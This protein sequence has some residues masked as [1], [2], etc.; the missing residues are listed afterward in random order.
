MATESALLA[1]RWFA[2]YA[3]DHRHP[4]NQQLHVICVP[5]I[6]WSILAILQC[7][8]APEVMVT[9]LAA[10][11]LEQGAWAALAAAAAVLFWLWLSLPLGIGTAVLSALCFWVNASILQSFGNFVLLIAGIAVFVLAWIGQFVGHVV[12][13]RRPSFFTDLVYLLIGPPW[14]LAKAYRLVGLER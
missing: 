6:V 14:A 7:L 13:G 3:D 1:E 4:V 9:V 2:A 10:I 5:A 12:E 11:G 8:P